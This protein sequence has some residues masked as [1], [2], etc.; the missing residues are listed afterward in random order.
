[1]CNTERTMRRPS[2][3]RVLSDERMILMQR[4]LV[5][6]HLTVRLVV[7]RKKRPVHEW[8]GPQALHEESEDQKVARAVRV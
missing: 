3:A 8:T 1:M 6:L 7:G 2:G 4:T 5:P